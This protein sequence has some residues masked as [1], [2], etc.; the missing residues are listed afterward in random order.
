MR[1]FVYKI[2]KRIIDFFIA[3]S[4]IVL[5][6]PFLIIIAIL[7]KIDS[8]GSII[9]K[10]ERV[11]R[12]GEI[13]YMYKF[14]SMDINSPN[15]PTCEITSSNCKI[16]RIGRILRKTSLDEIP[17]IL[18]I[19]KGDMSF[20]GPRPTIPKEADL[21]K[22]RKEYNIDSLYPGITGWA[23]INGRDKIDNITKVKLDYEY[24]QKK[25]IMFDFYIMLIT[26]IKVITLDGVNDGFYIS[27]D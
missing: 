14:R 19:I 18:N 16:T 22:M 17:Q 9:F 12:F 23:Q 25:S 2:I 27:K 15:I 21:T 20:V 11:G 10:Q 3:L 5:L 6:F 8:K 1:D 26:I 24:L 4:L 13:F 7:I